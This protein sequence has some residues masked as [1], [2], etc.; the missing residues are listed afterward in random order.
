M[1]QKRR[2]LVG[3]GGGIAAFKVCSLISQLVQT[4]ADVRG[5]VTRSGAQFITPLTVSTLC[6]HPVYGDQDFWQASQA[7]PLHIELGEWAELIVIAPL[8]ADSLGKLVHGL[9][10]NLLLNTVL[11]S[12]CPVLVAP[13]MN[14]T[15]WEQQPVQQNWKTLQTLQRFHSI[16]PNSGLLACDRVGAGRLAEPSQILAAVQSLIQ[17]G[18]QRDLAGQRL[19]ITAGGTREFLDPVRFL[20]NPSTGKMGIALAQA[21][22]H[23]RAAV[24][25]IHGPIASELLALVPEISRIPVISAQE[26]LD[27]LQANWIASDALIMAAAVGDFRPATYTAHKRSKTK[28]SD[29]LALSPVPDILSHLAQLKQTHQKLI[30]FAA[31]TGDFITPAREKLR[32][33][34][35]NAII[36]NPVDQPGAGFGS[37]QNFGVWLTPNAPDVPLT[38]GSKLTIAHQIYDLMQQLPLG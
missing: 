31:Q 6:R 29:K 22:L 16:G 2:I 25:L 17:T 24:M 12:T 27:A 37:E 19:L 8:T 35:L 9:A 32:R 11:A 38:S 28:F 36:A 33:K 34:Q 30:G 23:R 1:L 18:G 15:M 13:A 3:I 21:A 10:D 7:R 26:M 5:I 14:T 20:G 4:G